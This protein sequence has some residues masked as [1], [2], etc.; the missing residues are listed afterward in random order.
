MDFNFLEEY[1]NYS[2]SELLK[3]IKHPDAY[4]NAAVEAA[5]QILEVRDISEKDYEAATDVIKVGN[6]EFE[7]MIIK[8]DL[9][10]EGLIDFISPAYRSNDLFPALKW[11]N[12]FLIAIAIQYIWAL[13]HTAKYFIRFLKCQSC[14]FGYYELMALADVALIFTIFVF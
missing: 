1:K 5:K 12:V 11:L 3:I 9:T 4:Q 2:N 14:T 8:N 13:Y 6:A 7:N 10:E